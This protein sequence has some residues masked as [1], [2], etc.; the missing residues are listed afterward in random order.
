[1][2]PEETQLW[3]EKFYPASLE[4]FV[5]NPQAVEQAQRWAQEWSAGKKQTPLLLFGQ[6]GTGKTTLA[7]LIAK[8]QGWDVFELNASDFRSKDII[9]R[10]VGAASQ[11][12]SFTGRKRLVLLDE[13]DGLHRVDR[14]GAAAI[15]KIL[16]ETNN[17]VILTA[18]DVYADRKLLP[19][20]TACT[21]VEFKK[22]N[23]LSIAKRLR[24]LCTAEN[25]SF[26]DEAIAALAKNGGGDFRAA[27]L[28]VQ[29]LGVKGSINMPDVEN[30]GGRERTEKIFGILGKIFRG[31]T[32]QEIRNA[33]F[34]ADVN[35]EHLQ[36]W[37]DENI[38]RA[39]TKPI[40]TANAYAMLSR[41]DVFNGRIMKRQNWGFLRYSS[42]LA[43]AGVSL[44]REN[45]YHDFVMY[46]FPSLLS[47]MSR[48]KG[49]RATKKSLGRKVG[50]VTHSSSRSIVTRDLPYL[51][52]MFEN[53]QRAAEL[54]AQFDFDENEV[55]FLMNTKP[56]TKKVQKILEAAGAMRAEKIAERRKGAALSAVSQEDAAEAEAVPKP[57]AEEEPADETEKSEPLQHEDRNQTRLF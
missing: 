17:P 36:N 25:I 3:T 49:V 30:M 8:S 18:N 29:S 26:E 27:L 40:D 56:T 5:G 9:E 20:R 47:R 28:D 22:I 37:I 44:S 45:E 51:Q 53:K 19:V 1:M 33:R 15:T 13:V 6:T 35:T 48:S 32:L 12:G 55:A 39:L 24:E 54:T 23:Y 38:P 10:I 42:E 43:T 4:Q 52:T 21:L 41:A 16:K 46:K 7:Y 31:K 57:K 50:K 2:M 11:S 34:S 14:G